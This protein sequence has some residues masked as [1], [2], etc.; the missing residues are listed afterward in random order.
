MG[1]NLKDYE[2]ELPNTISGTVAYLNS[3]AV[4][5]DNGPQQY[6]VIIIPQGRTFR[7]DHLRIISGPASSSGNASVAIARSMSPTIYGTDN[8]GQG[9]YSTVSETDMVPWSR[10]AAGGGEVENAIFGDWA[11][12][13]SSGVRTN[14]QKGGRIFHY[15]LR[16]S[17]PGT[18]GIDVITPERGPIWMQSGDAMVAW[19]T[20]SPGTSGGY[21]GTNHVCSYIMSYM[22]FF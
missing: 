12:G 20:S 11:F 4:D 18:S 17:T 6:D 5:T 2:Y 19:T 16:Y 3:A 13:N 9:M 10:L 7:I 21:D 14:A 22:E 15:L 1:L 8:G